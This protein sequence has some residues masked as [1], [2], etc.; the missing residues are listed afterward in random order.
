MTRS[1]TT[2]G[3]STDTMPGR[4]SPTDGIDPLTDPDVLDDVP[5]TEE[6]RTI[7]DAELDRRDAWNGV[8]VVGAT[9]PSGAVL[10]AKLGDGHGWM[11]PNGPVDPGDDYVAAAVDWTE[12]TTGVTVDLDAVERVHRKQ[13]LTED[14][15]ETT[16]YHV[17]FAASPTGD[18]TVAD[19]PGLPGQSVES[20]GWF[21]EPP[22]DADWD[23]GDFGE[24]VRRFL[25]G[26]E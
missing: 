2:G 4:A 26:S 14:G 19:D 13:Y 9:D 10:L 24:D 23:H 6:T 22:A 18:A 8:A 11:L 1:P 25:E 15:R 7:S 5:V 12:Q 20:V 17:V 16:S 3:S 21:A